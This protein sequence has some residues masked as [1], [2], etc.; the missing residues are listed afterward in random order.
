MQEG[1]DLYF[2]QEIMANLY[3]LSIIFSGEQHRHQFVILCDKR[4]VLINIDYF[5]GK[6]VPFLQGMQRLQ[7]VFT[8]MT[9]R[10]RIENKLDQGISSVQ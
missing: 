5:N 4:I 7:H 10:S 2:I 8:E 1:V 3:R 9:V 6:R